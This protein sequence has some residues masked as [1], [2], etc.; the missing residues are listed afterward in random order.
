MIIFSQNFINSKIICLFVLCHL[1][2]TF[3]R[4]PI[5]CL[6]H[7]QNDWPRDGILRV[8][9]LTDPHDSHRNNNRVND[10]IHN[11]NEKLDNNSIEFNIN[12][13]NVVFGDD[14][15]AET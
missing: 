2:V 10:N 13:K 11:V 15:E 4:T 12:D 14:S 9:I 6:D 3:I 8:Q 1:H 7:I 5:N